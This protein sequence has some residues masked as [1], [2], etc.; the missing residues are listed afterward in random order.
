MIW[1]EQKGKSMEAESFFARWSKRNAEAAAEKQV[2][3]TTT[4]ESQ[5]IQPVEEPSRL[6]PTLDDVAQLT[7]D[8]DFKPFVAR[9][10]DENVRRSAMKKLFADPHFNV[11]DGLDIYIDDYTKPDPIPP[12][13]LLALN[14]AQALLNP[15]AHLEHPLMQLLAAVEPEVKPDARPMLQHPDETP[16]VPEPTDADARDNTP[17]TEEPLINDDPV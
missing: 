14:H 6:P 15:L 3:E 10:V 1:R 12:E 8:S 11:M 7:S 13:M 16:G 2:A 9:G 4:T 5:S 17:P